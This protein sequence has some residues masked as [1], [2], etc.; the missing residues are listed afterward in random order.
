[1][2]LLASPVAQWPESPTAALGVAR[3]YW[4]FDGVTGAWDL[5]SDRNLESGKLADIGAGAFDFVTPASAV[6]SG[7]AI[8]TAARRGSDTIVY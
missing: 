6:A 4:H 2:T 5:T 3:L 7:T 1:M 8:I